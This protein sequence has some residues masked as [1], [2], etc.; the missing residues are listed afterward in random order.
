MDT[1]ASSRQQPVCQEKTSSE[2]GINTLLCQN[3]KQNP[4]DMPKWH[5]WGLRGL[6]AQNIVDSQRRQWMHSFST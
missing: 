4:I 6:R 3:G 1:A 2:G 5:M